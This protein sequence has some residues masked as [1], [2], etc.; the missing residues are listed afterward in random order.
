MNRMGK[1]VN[2]DD[3]LVLGKIESLLSAVSLGLAVIGGAAVFIMMVHVTADVALKY[4]LHLPIV[5]TLEVVTF[6]YMCATVFLPFAMVQRRREHIIVEV[7]TQWLPPRATAAVDF[8]ASLLGAAFAAVL[9]WTSGEE[10][11]AQT[12]IGE[13]W[14]AGYFELPIWQSRWLVPIGCGTLTLYFLLHSVQ[15]FRFALT[16]RG[17]GH[18]R[19]R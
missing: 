15:D 19:S 2:Q 8:F 6:Y 14:D 12:L 10:A 7:F 4:L 3:A 16:G 1:T 5:G 11:I 18:R 17:S 13:I 9:T